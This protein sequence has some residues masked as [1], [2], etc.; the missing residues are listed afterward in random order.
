RAFVARREPSVQ[1]VAAIYSPESGSVE[2]EELVKTLLRIAQAAGAIFLPN[3][4]LKGA[5]PDQQELELTTERETVLAHILVNAGG[6]YADEV[7]QVLGGESFTIYP[8]RGEYA[9][10][11]P[12]KRGM[13][14]AHVYPLPHQHGLGVH[15][16]TTL[17]G[18]VLFGPTACYQARKDDYE[19]D[20]IPLE[21]FVEPARQLLP[22]LTI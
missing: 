7:S 12:A 1:A 13:V 18:A 14:N 19:G 4:P 3:T 16:T 20:R 10:L 9:E 17:A 21:D 8:C 11:T 22:G 15:I 5:T 2:A 6:L